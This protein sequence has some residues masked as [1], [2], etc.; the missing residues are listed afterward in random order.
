[1]KGT[2]VGFY[3]LGDLSLLD[4]AGGQEI[5]HSLAP[6]TAPWRACCSLRTARLRSR[7]RHR[8]TSHGV[9]ELTGTIYLPNGKLFINP[10]AQVADQSAYTA[11]VSYQL[12]L[13]EG[14]ELILNS[15]YGATMVPVLTASRH[16]KPGHAHQLK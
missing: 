16:I 4:I 14:P 2:N 13:T 11:I 10:N 7:A 3:L 1:M 8:I 15:S 5:R 9:R 12:E 6:R